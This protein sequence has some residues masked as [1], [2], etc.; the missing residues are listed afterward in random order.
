M[1]NAVPVLY[2]DRFS[3]Y[4]PVF[5]RDSFRVPHGIDG[6]LCLNL[7]QAGQENQDWWS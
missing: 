5:A 6:M 1:A 2:A 4:P 3:G 7:S